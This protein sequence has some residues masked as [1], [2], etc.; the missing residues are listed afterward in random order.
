MLS[1]VNFRI[2]LPRNVATL[3]GDTLLQDRSTFACKGVR[4]YIGSALEDPVPSVGSLMKP[5]LT[6]FS[7]ISS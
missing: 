3:E 2:K 1:S 4:R 5:A 6:I 7:K